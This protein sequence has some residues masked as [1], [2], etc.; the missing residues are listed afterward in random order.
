MRSPRTGTLGK[1]MK[2]MNVI[3]TSVVVSTLTIGT[4]FAQDPKLCGDPPVMDETLQKYKGGLDASAKTMANILIGGGLKGDVEIQRAS[5]SKNSGRRQGYDELLFAVYDLLN[6]D[7]Q[8]EVGHCTEG[9]S[10]K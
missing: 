4:A 9:G 5:V 10:V 2:S 1:F 8:Q 3:L 6:R 7:F